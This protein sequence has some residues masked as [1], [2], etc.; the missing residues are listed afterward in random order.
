MK[1]G[2]LVLLFAGQASASNNATVINYGSP[3]DN[4]AA[5]TCNWDRPGRDPFTGNIAAAVDRHQ[6]IPP[7]IRMELQRKIRAGALDDVVD[8][9]R[10][11]ITSASTRVLARLGASQPAIY[12]PEITAMHF[13]SG[14]VCETVTRAGWSADHVERA[15]VF[16]DSG[17]CLLVPRICNN[18]SRVTRI[19][20]APAEVIDNGGTGSI[21][22]PVIPISN[23][24]VIPDSNT[25]VP[26]YAPVFGVE[27]M[28]APSFN[29]C[30]F[31][32]P[33]PAAPVPEP[34]E[35]VMMG[36]GLLVVGIACRKR[37]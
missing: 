32:P 26:V 22:G 21:A 20:P 17:Y 10:D 35:W 11:S 3:V 15:K 25:G 27:T 4:F 16:C 12:G 6:D 18:I 30:C 36:M 34:S 5:R 7:S 8:I 19:D 13:G 31:A 37:I 14:K 24:G 29:G 9:R 2:L 23:T 1:A 33:V 28:P